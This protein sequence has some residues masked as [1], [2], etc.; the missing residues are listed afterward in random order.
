[1]GLGDGQIV[2]TF[3]PVADAGDARWRSASDCARVGAAAGKTVK[4]WNVADGKEILTLT[5][6]ANVAGL[7]FSADKAKVAAAAD[8]NLVHVWDMAK[9]L[10]IAVVP[11]RRPVKAVVFLPNAPASSAGGADKTVTFDTLNAARAV[12]VGSPSRP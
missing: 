5:H 10:E 9:G 12:A 3:G 7:S 1:M 11:P 6:P 8:D 2:R 4:V